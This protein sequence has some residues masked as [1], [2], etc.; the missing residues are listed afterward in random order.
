[1]PAQ[2]IH[3]LHGSSLHI[4]IS[5][6][7]LWL[8]RSVHFLCRPYIT[9]PFF[10]QAHTHFC[11][12]YTHTQLKMFSRTTLTSAS[13]LYTLLVALPPALCHVEMTWPAPLRSKHNPSTPENLIDYSM[14]A[15][16]SASG[17]NYPCKGY[18]HDLYQAP[19]ATY[20]AGST[21]NITLEGS[22]THG[23]GSCQLS[24]SYDQGQTFKVIKSMIGGCPEQ[25][26]Y[27]FTIPSYAPSGEAI[28]A[29]SWQNK[30]G[31][32]EFYMDC[33]VVQVQ[34]SQSKRQESYDSMDS[35]PGI[36]KADVQAVNDCTTVEGESPVYPHPGSD[37]QYGDGLD[38]SSPSSPGDCDG[39][40]SQLDSTNS[41]SS[42]PYTSYAPVDGATQA[43][44]APYPPTSLD[45]SDSYVTLKHKAA[46][47]APA[48]Y[49]ATDTPGETA[50]APYQ[51]GEP[52]T[53]ATGLADAL[54][55]G[56]TTTVFVDCPETIT[57]T[58]YPTET[59]AVSSNPPVYT[60]SVP[61]SA[62][63]GTAASC[64]CAAGYDCRLI[65]TCTW[66]CLARGQTSSSGFR[67]TTST[68]RSS[69]RPSI[70]RT[71]TPS[72][73]AYTSTTPQNPN[74]PPYASAAEIQTYLPCVPG[75]FICSS[76]TQWYTCDYNGGTDS[77]RPAAA[78]VYTAPRTVADGMECLPFL[79]PYS[80]SSQ[81]YA[82][83]NK[84]P[85]GY[86][87]DDRYVRARS[88]GDCE[89]DGATMCTD[90]GQGFSV[91][92]QGGW[93]RMGS[94]AEG[95]VCRDGQIVGA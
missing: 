75:T 12:Y 88:D 42:D 27:D 20:D 95:T 48:P 5:G 2:S 66:A 61:P 57:M 84:A 23:G 21:Y 45:D 32:R 52:T 39:M 94:V 80:A 91:C 4:Q 70:T 47:S 26:S 31:N 44:S 18:H 92:D 82:Q 56:S 90:G 3:A 40:T 50:P 55:T 19:S 62:C 60:T 13:A 36:W 11:S 77:S 76:A 53:I 79:V 14:K 81:Q 72:P 7:K 43:G 54:P 29:W 28:F 8:A 37:V 41:S 24:L 74:R 63:T 35:L 78:W 87:R 65:N 15:P 17:S 46:A 51:A 93:V 69:A 22:A 58:I 38:S 85:Q 30:I 67:T 6:G 86:Y 89:R 25:S 16:L 33:A 71:Q 10:S 49:T 1:M 83:Q 64:P 34:G 9:V 73:P 59:P 68:A